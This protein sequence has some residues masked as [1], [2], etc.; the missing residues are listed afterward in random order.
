MSDGGAQRVRYPYVNDGQAVRYPS[1][2][3][4]GASSQIQV[5][6]CEDVMRRV[7]VLREL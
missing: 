2:N 7:V 1:V 3:D 6:A 5:N 4:S